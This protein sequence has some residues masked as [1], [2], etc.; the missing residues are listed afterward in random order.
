[1]NSTE[2][3]KRKPRTRSAL[4]SI[5]IVR[6]RLL[7]SHTW[8]TDCSAWPAYFNHPREFDLTIEDESWQDFVHGHCLD[9]SSDE[10]S[11]D[12]ASDEEGERIDESGN[13]ATVSNLQAHP[14]GSVQD[15]LRTF[16]TELGGEDRIPLRTQ[17]VLSFC[18]H[19]KGQLGAED[20]LDSK[21]VALV[22][23]QSTA[24]A[25]ENLPLRGEMSCDLLTR[26]ELHKRLN[27]PVRINS[28]F[29]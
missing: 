13:T 20:D 9:S 3:R 6:P 11:D 5:V 17:E 14:S 7:K 21:R 23:D 2:L 24:K 29:K 22:D 19:V 10:D 27:K 18:Q 15:P 4:P 12:S 26:S 25:Q 1:M 8:P 28:G 16:M